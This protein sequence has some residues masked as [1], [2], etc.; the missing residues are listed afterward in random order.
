M[1]ELR[2]ARTR[3]EADVTRAEDR[4][5]SVPALTPVLPI[6][7][8]ERPRRSG[9]EQFG[10]EPDGLGHLDVVVRGGENSASSS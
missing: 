5:P 9:A 10:D 2:Q 6:C 8:G 4:D 3:H 7:V 1:A